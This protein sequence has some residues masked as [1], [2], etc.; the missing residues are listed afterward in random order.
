MSNRGGVALQ[1]D[2]MT[3]SGRMLCGGGFTAEGGVHLAHARIQGELSFAGAVLADDSAV[4]ALTNAAVADLNLR[5]AQPIACI[6]DL[7]HARCDVLRD[8][9]SSW[10]RHLALD[11]LEYQAIDADTP[12][13]RVKRRLAWLRRDRDGYR[14]QPYEQLAALY[15]RQGADGDA[16]RVLLE[17]QRRR[18]RE[19]GLM[20]RA[21]GRLLEWTVGYGYRPWRAALWLLVM[22]A[23]GTAVFTTWPPE[24]SGPAER[25]FDAWVYTLDLLVPI[26]GFGQRDAFV[27]QGD[28]RWVAY[29]LTAAGWLLATAI[30]AGIT[31]ALR[32]D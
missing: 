27:P 20:T 22:L 7:R 15:R 3:V 10:P 1:G 21:V 32:R 13:L 17:K 25:Q 12:S 23:A 29:G 28:T 6:V 8:E 18:A 9:S 2:N 16:R 24:P 30:V 14:P 31:R 5:A 26:V 11:G 19:L 4:L